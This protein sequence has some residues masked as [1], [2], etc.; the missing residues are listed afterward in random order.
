MHM[1]T[2][3]APFEGGV[4][5]KFMRDMNFGETFSIR[6]GHGGGR[7]VRLSGMSVCSTCS[8]FHPELEM[9]KILTLAFVAAV[10]LTSVAAIGCGDKPAGASKK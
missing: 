10:A 1:T 8:F 7:I 6:N 3:P 9:K 4:S 5:P 2:D